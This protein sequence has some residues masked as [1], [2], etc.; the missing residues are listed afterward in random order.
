MCGSNGKRDHPV[1]GVISGGGA[2]FGSAPV[3]PA[4]NCAMRNARV[5]A[6]LKSREKNGDNR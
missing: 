6:K 4:T 2:N 3:T 5:L 1:R